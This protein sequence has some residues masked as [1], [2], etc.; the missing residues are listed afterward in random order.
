M[1][2][3][4]VGRYKH[5]GAKWILRTLKK[6]KIR[7]NSTCSDLISVEKD[8]LALVRM[9][10]RQLRV[11]CD[12]R[13]SLSYLALWLYNHLL[14]RFRLTLS[15]FT[16]RQWLLRRLLPRAPRWCTWRWSR[17]FALLRWLRFSPLVLYQMEKCESFDFRDWSKGNA[18]NTYV[19]RR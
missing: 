7:R 19:T 14:H 1:L 13:W 11:R 9:C 17:L 6:K 18:G 10:W 2:S 16:S 12:L 3:K 5:R 8:D 4:L 15:F